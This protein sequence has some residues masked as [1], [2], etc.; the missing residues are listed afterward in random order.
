MSARTDFT[1]R[2]LHYSAAS[3]AAMISTSAAHA[4]IVWNG[5]T[6]SFDIRNGSF[7]FV[8]LNSDLTDDLS[9]QGAAGATL[10]NGL[11]FGRVWLTAYNSAFAAKDG[12]AANGGGNGDLNALPV[13]FLIGPAVG[14]DNETSDTLAGT[15]NNL[16]VS[17]YGNFQHYVGEVRYIG[18]RFNLG[19]G[20]LFGWIAIRLNPDLLSGDLLGFAYEDLGNPIAAGDTGV[21]G[22]P[23]PA[24][25]LL[26]AAGAAGVAA[27]R[28]RRRTS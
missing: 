2:F 20:D 15:F 26:M 19:T 17:T 10:T 28:Q 9:I 22:V 7:A 24:S 1:K 27:L 4:G 25:I 8:D 3:A 11:P 23:E 18:L 6:Q 12:S 21:A 13:G 16:G 14:F 5:T